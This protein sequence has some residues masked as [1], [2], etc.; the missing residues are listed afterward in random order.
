MKISEDKWAVFGRGMAVMSG[1]IFLTVAFYWEKNLV[2]LLLRIWCAAVG[3]LFIY[4][5]LRK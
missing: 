5:A 4:V 3:A 1:I 2:S